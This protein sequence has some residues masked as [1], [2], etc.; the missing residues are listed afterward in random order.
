VQK[1]PLLPAGG[2]LQSLALHRNDEPSV[3]A[4]KEAL[5]L[6]RPGCRAIILN[7]LKALD[8]MPA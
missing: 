7:L 6:R 1:I 5:S 4:R 3:I 8:K 2:L